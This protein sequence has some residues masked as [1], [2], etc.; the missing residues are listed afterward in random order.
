MTNK[1]KSRVSVGWLHLGGIA[2]IVGGFLNIVFELLAFLSHGPSEF[3]KKIPVF[4]MLF[5]DYQRL[6]ILAGLLTLLAFIVLYKYLAASLNRLGRVAFIILIVG[7][8]MSLAWKILCYVVFP[9]PDPRWGMGFIFG[10]LAIPVLLVGWLILGIAL[11]RIH[12]EPRWV[13]YLPFCMAAIIVS[14]IL[15]V[16]LELVG[17]VGSLPISPGL[18]AAI[19]SGLVWVAFG[20]FLLD[21]TRLR[22]VDNAA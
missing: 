17:G 21:A 18:L 4:G 13:T 14:L 12:F 3:D 22:N 20:L 11:T 16:V 8:L 19:G 5:A 1:D 2:A 10:V 6:L 9:Y 7:S 15:I